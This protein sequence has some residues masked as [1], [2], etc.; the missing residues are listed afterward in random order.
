MCE[1]SDCECFLHMQNNLER[2]EFETKTR[3][4]RQIE[5]LDRENAVLRQKAEGT[6]G[7]QRAFVVTL[8]VSLRLWAMRIIR[9]R[10]DL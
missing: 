7:E 2:S 4:T 6:D 10:Y 8:E 9:P 3:L 5:K 1:S